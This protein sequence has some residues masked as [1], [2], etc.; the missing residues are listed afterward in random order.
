MKWVSRD[1]SI[2]FLVTGLSRKMQ[3][4]IIYSSIFVL[5]NIKYYNFNSSGLYSGIFM[6]FQNDFLVSG[7]PYYAVMVCFR[8]RAFKRRRSQTTGF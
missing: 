8:R 6:N 5:G 1:P 4:N 7:D 2:T 3:Q